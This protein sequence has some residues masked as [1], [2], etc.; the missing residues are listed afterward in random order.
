MVVFA[1]RSLS[2]V[3]IVSPLVFVILRPLSYVRIAPALV[4]VAALALYA[5]I[6]VVAAYVGVGVCTSAM[7][8]VAALTLPARFAIAS[9]GVALV[10]ANFASAALPG[11][12]SVLLTDA[13]APIF[14]AGRLLFGAAPASFAVSVIF[15]LRVVA[16]VFRLL[17][18]SVVSELF[19]ASLFSFVFSVLG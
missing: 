13:P 10:S 7:V 1:F 2:S 6:C 14:F 16:G 19:T 9:C 12:A 18:C 4:V 5:R 8:I 11:V 17:V 15:F 3:C